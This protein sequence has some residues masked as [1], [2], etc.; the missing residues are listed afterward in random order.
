MWGCKYS[1]IT[2]NIMYWK[3]TWNDI[4]C[5][6]N[7]EKRVTSNIASSQN[8]RYTRF[9]LLIGLNE[10]VHYDVTIIPAFCQTKRHFRWSLHKLYS[11]LFSGD[12]PRMRPIAQRLSLWAQDMSAPT[13]SLITA[14]Q[15]T[16]MSWGVG[17]QTVYTN[18]PNFHCMVENIKSKHW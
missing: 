13:V 18:N 7:A 10:I 16:L 6:D 2:H 3:N 15:F 8:Q 14:I 4:W 17:E 11:K 9:S 5:S 1:T 12:L